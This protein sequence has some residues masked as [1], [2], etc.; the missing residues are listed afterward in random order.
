MSQLQICLFSRF[1]ITCGQDRLHPELSTKAQELCS[2]LVL[3]RNRS[4]SREKLATLLWPENYPASNT[5]AYLRKALWQLQQGLDMKEDVEPESFLHVTPEWIQF[6]GGD[7]F[8][9][10]I[11]VFE[12]AYE[13]TRGC[14][15]RS[16]SPQQADCIKNAVDLYQ[17]DLLENWYLEWCEFERDRLQNVYLI[18]LDK[19]LAHCITMKDVEAGLEYGTRSLKID[20]A[21]ESTY[22][23]LMELYYLAG[24]RTR[25]LRMY[26]QCEGVLRDELD[27]EPSPE[28]RELY[29][30]IRMGK[31]IRPVQSVS[32]VTSGEDL[33]LRERLERIRRL[34]EIHADIQSQIKQNITAVEKAL[35]HSND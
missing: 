13:C 18:M 25:G 35:K 6:S 5:K 29:N 30:Q 20:R 1:E 24:N 15:G 2:Y 27:I 23:Q 32:S 33:S 19:L 16:L 34:Q 28:T 31:M 26:E 11:E 14:Q 12:S 17:G 22:R 8:L 10:D 3:N 7:N 21:R 9:I 4:H